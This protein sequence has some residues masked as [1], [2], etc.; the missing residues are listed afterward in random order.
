MDERLELRV[1]EYGE[2]RTLL[3]QRLLHISRDQN[4]I[5]TVAAILSDVA[6]RGDAAVLEYTNRFDG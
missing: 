1:V 6:A 5:E 4:T 3:R 2:A